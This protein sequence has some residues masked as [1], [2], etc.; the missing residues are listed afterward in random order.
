MENHLYNICRR[1]YIKFSAKGIEVD[2]FSNLKHYIVC[3]WESSFSVY[4]VFFS[5]FKVSSL[6]L[7]LWSILNWFSSGWEILI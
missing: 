4:C 6:I 1:V 2:R 7:G 5:S 3:E